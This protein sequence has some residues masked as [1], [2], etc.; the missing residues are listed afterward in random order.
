MVAFLCS[1][2]GDD[3]RYFYFPQCNGNLRLNIVII[4]NLIIQRETNKKRRKR[5]LVL[6]SSELARDVIDVMLNTRKII[7]SL[8]IHV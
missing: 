5:G 7:I 8:F 6:V 3:R 4:W 1:T 2:T